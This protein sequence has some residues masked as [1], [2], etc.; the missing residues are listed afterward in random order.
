MHVELWKKNKFII[1]CVNFCNKIILCKP[2]YC[3]KQYV[4]CECNKNG[5]IVHKNIRTYSCT[6]YFI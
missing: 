5:K 2:M 6:I 1:L 4:R 3:T